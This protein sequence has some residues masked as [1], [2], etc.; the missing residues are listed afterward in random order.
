MRG[1]YIPGSRLRIQ[2]RME[3]NVR[4]LSSLMRGER[5]VKSDILRAFVRVKE[6]LV[7]IRGYRDQAGSF[8]N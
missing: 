7:S 5:R 3:G 4:G 6:G 2:C 8:D 1:Y